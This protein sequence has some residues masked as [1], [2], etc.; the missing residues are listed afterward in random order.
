MRKIK[1]LSVVVVLFYFVAFVAAC[2]SVAK[3][4]PSINIFS[5]QDDVT[6]GQQVVGEINQNP[7]EYPLWTG[8]RAE[9]VKSY[10]TNHIVNDILASPSIKKRGVYNYNVQIIQKDSE[11]NAFALPGGPIY[12]YSGLLK[13]LD[14]EAALA[15]VI[16]HEIAHAEHRHAT[17]RMTQY[18]GVS[19]LVSAVLGEKPSQI[20]EIAANL[21]V[22][23]AF[24]QNSRADEDESDQSSL[25]YLQGTKYYPGAV[26][27]FFEKMQA[28]GLIASGSGRVDAFLSTHPQPEQRISLTNQRLQKAGLPVLDY[29]YSGSQYN[30]YRTE[31]Q[32][33]IKSKMP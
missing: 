8:P 23:L 7:S 19:I 4:F 20:A 3:I 24:L 11:L 5:D 25:Q 29:R 15:G 1:N 12:I 17:Q 31:Y 21:L 10:I 26:K 33:N 14:S 9:Q 16:G 6:L 13:Y 30:M 27:F 2:S 28:D 18:Y 22:G 32:N